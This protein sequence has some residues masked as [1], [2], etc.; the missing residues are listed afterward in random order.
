MKNLNTIF[1]QGIDLYFKNI[2]KQYWTYINSIEQSQ[3]SHLKF[4]ISL[5]YIKKIRKLSKFRKLLVFLDF[6]RNL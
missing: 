3:L 4:Q 5:F 1:K 6:N 2:S